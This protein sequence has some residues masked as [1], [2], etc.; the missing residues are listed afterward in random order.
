MTSDDEMATMWKR[1]ESAIS[2]HLIGDIG[3]QG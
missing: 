2:I 1:G 3:T